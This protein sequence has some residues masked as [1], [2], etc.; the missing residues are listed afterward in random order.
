MNWFAHVL[1]ASRNVIT[2]CLTDQV[3]K[4]RQIQAILLNFMYSLEKGRSP[5]R[6][7]VVNPL[8]FVSIIDY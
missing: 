7:K 8:T 1:P 4:L 5:R 6:I 2:Y 3:A